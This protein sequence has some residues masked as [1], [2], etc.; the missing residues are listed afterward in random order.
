MGL[1]GP[2]PKPTSIR[3]L[4]G[5]PDHRPLPTSEPKYRVGVPRRPDGM[6]TGARKIWD[7][8]VGE[9]APS[10]VLRTV[11]AFALAQLCEDQAMLNTLRKGLAEM[12]REIAKKAKEQKLELPGGPM[13]QLSRTTEGRRT[14]TTIKELSLQVIVQRREFGLTPASNSRVQG[15]GG[16]A[17]LGFMD[18][19]E[20]A[21][22]G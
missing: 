11:D 21:L 18:P 16:S 5:M 10:C 19:L 20:R 2:P 9:M 15:A 7:E 6:S 3:V 12:S 1:R 13:I 8:L 14:L 4:E 17:A 22:C